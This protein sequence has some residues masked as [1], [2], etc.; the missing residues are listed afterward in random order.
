MELRWLV[1]PS[2]NTRIIL[3]D[4]GGPHIIANHR[5]LKVEEGAEKEA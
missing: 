5:G 4:L 1:S 2:Y 3:D